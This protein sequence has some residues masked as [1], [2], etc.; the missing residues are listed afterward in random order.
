MTDDLET[1]RIRANE[2]RQFMQ[3]PLFKQAF[4][5]VASDLEGV[6][7]SCDPDNKDKSQRII[8]AKQLLQAVRREIE[9]RVEDGEFAQFQMSELEKRRGLKAIFQR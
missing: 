8:I 1:R 5:G 3:N 4:D 2:A 6:A 9:R 7:L